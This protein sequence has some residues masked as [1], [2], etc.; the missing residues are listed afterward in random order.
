MDRMV[1]LRDTWTFKVRLS[2]AT[3]TRKRTRRM[4]RA[5]MMI[6][7]VRELKN[8]RDKDVAGDV[9][10]ALTIVMQMEVGRRR[11]LGDRY[12]TCH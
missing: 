10:S 11:G 3:A 1:Q 6:P 7:R 5:G 8:P 12:S 2:L 9:E 4:K